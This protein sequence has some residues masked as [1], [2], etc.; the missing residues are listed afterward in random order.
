MSLIMRI[1][2]LYIALLALTIPVAT[3]QQKYYYTLG[4]KYKGLRKD[5]I[6]V[7]RT[8][9]YEVTRAE[10][11]YNKQKHK[12]YFD[13]DSNL[14]AISVVKDNSLCP[15][16]IKSDFNCIYRKYKIIEW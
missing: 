16:Y 1:T 14:T 13:K 10:F 4:S 2:F 7:I 11:V 5:Q 12:A 8:W 15:S 9:T 3:A 6:K